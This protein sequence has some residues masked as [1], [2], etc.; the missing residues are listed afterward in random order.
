MVAC[1]QT[2]IEFDHWPTRGLWSSKTTEVCSNCGSVLLICLVSSFQFYVWIIMFP[3]SG[4]NGL[5]LCTIVT[6]AV[7]NLM[8]YGPD[9]DYN[10]VVFPVSPREVGCHYD[11]GS[12]FTGLPDCIWVKLTWCIDYLVLRFIFRNKMLCCHCPPTFFSSIISSC[13][14]SGLAQCT[15]THTHTGPCFLRWA[16]RKWFSSWC[17]LNLWPLC[18]SDYGGLLTAGEMSFIV[19]GK[20]HW[21]CYRVNGKT[22]DICRDVCW[23]SAYF[24]KCEKMDGFFFSLLIW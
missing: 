18:L 4:V 12:E 2:H 24:W 6:A 17:I 19:F 16:N 20:C 8:F 14:C 15:H 9:S 7:I 23:N 3:T 22:L 10:M 1:S 13:C 21:C 5:W 11:G